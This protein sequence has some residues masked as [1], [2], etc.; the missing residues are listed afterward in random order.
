MKRNA[1]LY[2]SVGGLV[3]SVV[4][5]F[6]PVIS[7]TSSSNRH[8][9]YNLVSI[10]KDS[11]GFISQTLSEYTGNFLYN[12]SDEQLTVLMVLIS[13]IG[14]TALMLAAI[15]IATLSQQK[16]NVGPFVLALLGLVGTAIPALTLLVM[17]M[18]SGSYFMGTLR[19]GAY[20]IV[21][22]IAMVCAMVAVTYKRKATLEELRA[23]ELSRQ[24]WSDPGT[25]Q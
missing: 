5:L 11:Y 10:V 25:R 1:W 12:S 18:L 2:A 23:Q 9:S 3:L 24:Y 21:T 17:Y 4:T 16:P 15:G 14:V 6:L 20:A 22:P 19:I 8:Y 7:Y 13:V